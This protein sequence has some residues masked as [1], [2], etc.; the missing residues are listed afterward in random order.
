[1]N[2]AM[3]ELVHAHHGGFVIVAA[4]VCTIGAA[5]TVVLLMRSK[6]LRRRRRQLHLGLAA[7]IAGT[8]IW[9]THFIGMLGYS[10]AETTAYEPVLTGLSLLIAIGGCT[11]A[12]ALA[13]MPQMR[14]RSVVGG[15]L[16][17]L[18]VTAMHYIGMAALQ[19]PG[20]FEWDTDLVILSII[21]GSVFGMIMV[22]RV[23]HPVT[24]F[25]WAG[26]TVAMV[27]SVCTMHFTGM[28]A[29]TFV[30]DSSF[31]VPARLIS[32][33]VLGF[34][35]LTV[36][37]LILLIGFTT[38]V[39]ETEM[40]ADTQRKL[41]DA[42][43]RDLLTT[44]PNR[45]GFAERAAR[46]Q[47]RVDQGHKIRIAVL[48][49]DLDLFKQINDTMGHATGDIVL[50]HVADQMNAV[51]QDH[52]FI[53]RIGGDEF[54]A[55][56]SDLTDPDDAREFAMRLQT[57][58]GEPLYLGMSDLKLG[59]SIGIATYPDDGDQLETLQQYSDLAMYQ[60]KGQSR[61]KIEFYDNEIEQ[62][63]REK[64]ALMGDLSKAIDREELF[65]HYQFQNSIV[66]H[67][68]IGFEVLLRWRHPERGLIGPNVFIPLAEET[69]LIKDIGMWVMRTACQEAATWDQPYP[70]AVNV[71]PQ[72]LIEPD[73][74]TQVLAILD[75][76]QLAPER[77]EV[78]I[79]E[80]TIIQ[81]QDNALAVMHKLKSM[82]IR[83]AMD[84]FGTGYSSL[85][86]LQAFPFDKI[87]IDRSFVHNVHQSRQNAAIVRATLLLGGALDVPVLA[88][89]AEVAE[90]IAFLAGE[91][92]DA[93]QGYFFGKPMPVDDV[94]DVTMIQARGPKIA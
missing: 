32:N 11:A 19:V 50:R 9:A 4:F 42:V 47:K 58:I 72:Q 1:M 6:A 66:S 41:S 12:V 63:R 61:S 7:M 44:L 56:K 21:F 49:I 94:R 14:W 5:L 73:F 83:I 48:T 24:R 34:I 67:A 22:H 71:S 51:L 8:T 89:G 20:R 65:L 81:D 75:D 85:S 2:H 46:L 82:G 37:S 36:V 29:A 90:E 79:T 77:L 70:I 26:A 45:L 38:F 18:T 25:C 84:D 16:F 39:I 62:R 30:P 40:S 68:I 17:G 60:A 76:C 53:A 52:E 64:Q 35:V 10:P 74:V 92:C 55:L 31:I 91:S 43:R 59:V 86:T 88:E 78:E 23:M 33:F 57:A 27:L 54:A 87:K 15:T 80:A 28:A 93:V 3:S 13:A 69:G